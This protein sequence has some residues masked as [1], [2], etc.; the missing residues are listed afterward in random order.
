MIARMIGAIICWIFAGLCGW[1]VYGIISM[2]IN[3]VISQNWLLAIAG[4]LLAYF[5][6]ILLL[7]GAILLTILGITVLAGD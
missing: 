1:G 5:F 6:G 7:I 2:V 3:G 4:G